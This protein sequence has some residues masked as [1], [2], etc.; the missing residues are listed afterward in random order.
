MTPLAYPIADA[1]RVS[2]L[3]RSQLDRAIRAGLLAARRSSRGENGEG[4]GKYLVKHA[5]LVAYIDSLPE[6]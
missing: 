1:V 5:D 2:G 4:Q 6:A 3:S